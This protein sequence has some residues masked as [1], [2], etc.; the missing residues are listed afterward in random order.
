MT[1]SEAVSVIAPSLTAR[2]SRRD[3]AHNRLTWM[4]TGGTGL[5]IGAISVAFALTNSGVGEPTRLWVYAA[6]YVTVALVLLRRHPPAIGDRFNHFV[7]AYAYTAT[8]SG[9]WVF[10]PG[11]GAS[12][13][14]GMFIGPLIAVRLQDRRQIAAH[15][16]LATAGL[17]G[18]AVIGGLLGEVDTTTWIGIM[19]MLPAMWVLGACCT[20]VL[21][22]S[23][24]QGEELE[25]LVRRDPLTGVGNRRLLDEQLTEEVRRHARSGQPLSLL[26]LDL[27]GFKA[28]N[29]TLGHAAGD[30]LLRDVATALARSAR[31]QDTVVRQ[32]GDEFCVL[33][34]QTSPAHA[35]RMA[36]TIRA[37][38]AGTDT[39]GLVSTGI[40]IATYPAD[41]LTGGVLLHVADERLIADKAGR[42]GRGVLPVHAASFD[43]AA[44]HLDR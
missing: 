34:P 17:L 11:G 41:A 43:P 20:V 14:S 42:P 27:N 32:G 5:L 39:G 12:I 24:A 28:L 40:G 6:V 25:R 8:I 37:N 31:P 30:E 44:A 33:L 19:V 1:I 7:L 22:A 9:M 15:L 18:V 26:A 35:E 36:N 13:A 23:E 21:E 2:V 29:D 16:A 4:A 10:Q 38:L 3:L